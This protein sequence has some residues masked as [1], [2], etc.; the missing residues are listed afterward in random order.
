MGYEFGELWGFESDGFFQTIEET[1]SH[2]QS[3]YAS[4]G[5]IPF[6]V[7]SPKWV[8]Q[9]GNG[10]IEKGYT[11]SDPKDHRIIGNTS[12]RYRFGVNLNFGWRGF[13]LSTFVQGIGKK[14]YYPLNRGFW[15]TYQGMAFEPY[16]HLWD[17]YRPEDDSEEER[18]GHSQSY[19]DAGLA[20]A[21]LDAELPILQ[22]WNYRGS[23]Y[24]NG[25][26]LGIPQ[27]DFLF[28]ARY[29]RLK[30]ITLGYTLPRTVSQKIRIQNLRIF[31]S[32]ENLAEWSP[33]L[34]FMDPE[35]FTNSVNGNVYPFR[36]RYSFG[37]N[38]D[39]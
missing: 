20:D 10:I 7:G 4:W 21:N 15:G 34:F 14:D 17:F 23:S 22:A 6:L 25:E 16:P 1:Q 31:I 8:D 30:N 38:I 32:G 24:S 35:E 33:V 18:A 3:R 39:F 5:A 19:I 12:P 26:G 37:I 28:N 13:D 29:I 2:D 9:D 11:V 36:R 27:T